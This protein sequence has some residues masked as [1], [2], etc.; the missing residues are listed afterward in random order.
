[1]TSK[2]KAARVIATPAAAHINKNSGY[3]LIGQRFVKAAIVVA[4]LRGW[5]PHGVADWLIQH[6]GLSHV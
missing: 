6:G 1:M 3:F 4:A 5:L 2:E